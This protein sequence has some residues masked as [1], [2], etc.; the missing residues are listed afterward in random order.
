[1]QTAKPSPFESQVVREQPQSFLSR[2]RDESCY[3]TLRALIT[4][5]ASFIAIVGLLLVVIATTAFFNLPSGQ[6]DA[7][8]EVWTVHWR[9][10]F[11]SALWVPV[12]GLFTIGAAS[13]FR[14]ASLLLA[15]IADMIIARGRETWRFSNAT[16]GTPRAGTID[17]GA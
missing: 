6:P 2:V 12:S 7:V 13:A 14:Q 9:V 1:M 4:L 8:L 10:T 3:K 17:K 5:V 11:L 16:T 15:D